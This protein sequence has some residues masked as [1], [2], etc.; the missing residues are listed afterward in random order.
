MQMRMLCLRR[1]VSVQSQE[2][3]H[4]LVVIQPER[5]ER[6]RLSNLVREGKTT[7]REAHLQGEKSSLQIQSHLPAQEARSETAQVHR[8]A[9]P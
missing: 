3:V 2:G 6:N 1:A 4:K 9:G 5:E 8:A 7:G